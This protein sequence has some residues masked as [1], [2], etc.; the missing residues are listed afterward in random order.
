MGPPRLQKSGTETQFCLRGHV[1]GSFRMAK[2]ALNLFLGNTEVHE[3]I[4]I[5]YNS[6]I[7]VEWLLSVA[8][9]LASC[10][11]GL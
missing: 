4:A 3:G 5:T 7:R 6:W 11:S 10:Y 1:C 2:V 8:F 9:R